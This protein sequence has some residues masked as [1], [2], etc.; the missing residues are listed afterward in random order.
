MLI[1]VPE[2][3]DSRNAALAEAFAAAFHGI[4]CA[5]RKGGSALVIGGGPIGLALVKLL[6]VLAFAPVALSEPVR[7]KQDLAVDFG[8][9]NVIDPFSEDLGQHV[10]EWT[11]GIGF[12]TVFECSGAA[13]AVQ[14]AIDATARGGTL[15]IVSVIFES[16]QITPLHMTFKEIRMTASYSNTHEENNQILTWMAQGKLDGRPL[17]TDVIPLD[18]LP[19]VYKERIETGKAVKVMMHIGE[20]F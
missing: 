1:P 5:G 10:F 3:V 20:E 15:C 7:A 13:G 9:D 17:I 11:K 19:A 14:T 12:E 16:T 8:A 18:R 4:R 2:G 6:K